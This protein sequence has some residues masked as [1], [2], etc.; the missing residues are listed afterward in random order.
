MNYSVTRK[1][2]RKTA[3]VAVHPDNSVSVVVARVVLHSTPQ[4]VIDA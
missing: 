4:E 3:S 1:P 2:K